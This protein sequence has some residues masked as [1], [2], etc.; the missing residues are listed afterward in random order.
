MKKVGIINYGMGNIVSVINSIKY[1]GIN[2]KVIENQ[3]Q[4]SGFSHYIL[5]GVGSFRAAMKNI[6]KLGFDEK[7]N[8]EITE[9]KRGLL[10]ICLGMQLMGF[11]STENGNTKGLGLLKNK[12]VKFENNK[13]IKF[14][15]PHIGFNTIKISST[16]SFFF[17]NIEQNSDF[18]FVHSY[19]MNKENLKNNYATCT[20]GQNFL[21]AFNKENIFGTQ[22][23]PE[24]SQSNGLKL[25]INF[26]KFNA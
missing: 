20:Y 6:K 7:I 17:K 4:F 15:L 16:D 13:L 18:Y 26:L 2:Y 22:F 5:P 23:H 24:K 19:K 14:N 25:L 11:S 21:A 9:Q 8:Q 12:V 10:G 1:L 3:K